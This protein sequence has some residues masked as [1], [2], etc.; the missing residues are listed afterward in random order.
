MGVVVSPTARA[1][2]AGEP[3]RWLRNIDPIEK[4]LDAPAELELTDPG[5]YFGE[6]IGEEGS[7]Q[8]YII[9][10][11]PRDSAASPVTDQSLPGIALNSFPRLLALA[12]RFHD[13][14]LLFSG[15]LTSD[16]R[17]VFRRTLRGRLQEIAP[18]LVWD[19]DAHPIID[20]GRVIWMVD[21][22]IATPTFPLA[23]SLTLRGVGEIRY[24]RNSVKATI[25]A[26]TGEVTL[27]AVDLDDPI[28]ETYRRIFP[29]LI[30]D[31][32]LMPS[33]LLAHLRYPVLYLRAQAEILT[34]YHLDQREAFFAGQDFW[35]TPT[36]GGQTSEPYHP[37]YSLMALPGE[38]EPEFLLSTP[39]IARERQNMTALLVAR[40][41]PPHSGELILYEL[42]RDQQILGPVQIAA[43]MEQDPA[44]S[45][46]LALWGQAGSVVRMGRLRVVPLDSTFLFVRPVFLSPRETSI[47]EL[48]RLIVSDG[49]AV[50]MASNLRGAVEG[51]R[52]DHA[53]IG[54]PEEPPHRERPEYSPDQEGLRIRARELLDEAERRLRAGDWEGFGVSWSALRRL[55][56]GD[57]ERPPLDDQAQSRPIQP[58]SPSD[59]AL[60][61]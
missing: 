23:R 48:A 22:Y 58:P 35:Q 31:L 38:S 13:K 27:Y 11:P 2:S 44:I 1:T 50:Q 18:F 8:E 15:D 45:P 20:G 43:L 42:P 33:S 25:D 10:S 53:D 4:A 36:A 49:R 61:Q 34:E 37:L 56:D 52:A 12:W 41:D 57:S 6:T 54:R 29:G 39:F 30:H 24:L 14:N 16:S 21:G 32:E 47:P 17:F 9:L 46:Q 55:L 19:S 60:Q 3:I 7:G 51:L 5:I 28:L 26:T 59:P 40:S